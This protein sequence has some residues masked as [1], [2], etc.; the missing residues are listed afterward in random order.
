VKLHQWSTGQEGFLPAIDLP[1]E[2]LMG[3]EGDDL[4]LEIAEFDG[5]PVMALLARGQLYWIDGI[6]GE[7]TDVRPAGSTGTDGSLLTFVRPQIIVSSGMPAIFLRGKIWQAGDSQGDSWLAPFTFGALGYNPDP[8]FMRFRS[9]SEGL[10]AV[11]FIEQDWD[12]LVIQG[13]LPD[14]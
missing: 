3:G 6:D 11:Q 5:S 14:Q 7:S 10:F 8:D 1:L 12:R 9:N 4:A 2:S 13:E